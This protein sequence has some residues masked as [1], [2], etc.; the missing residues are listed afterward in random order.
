MS[1]I[2]IAGAGFSV[3]LVARGQSCAK[4]AALEDRK[5]DQSFGQGRAFAG[6]RLDPA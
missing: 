1:R 5:P 3:H 2:F 6:E 4:V